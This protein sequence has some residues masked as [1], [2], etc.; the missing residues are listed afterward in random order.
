MF[1]A[2]L[3]YELP[4]LKFLI[5]LI[6]FSSSFLFQRKFRIYVE[7]EISVPRMYELG[8]PQGSVLSP[9]LCSICVLLQI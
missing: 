7:G 1:T 5:I 9:T 6:K 8:V 3:L 2:G 4:Y